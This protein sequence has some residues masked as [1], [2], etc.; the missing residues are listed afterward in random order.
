MYGNTA[1]HSTQLFPAHFLLA[2]KIF[3]GQTYL[4]NQFFTD[5]CMHMCD[6]MGIFISKALVSE[7]F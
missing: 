7:K 4:F 6:F 5:E 2:A 3:T 1:F